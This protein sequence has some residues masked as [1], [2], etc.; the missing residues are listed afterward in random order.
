SAPAPLTNSVS[1]SASLAATPGSTEPF[2]PVRLK[3][4]VARAPPV[5]VASAGPAQPVAQISAPASASPA[6]PQAERTTSNRADREAPKTIA[7]VEPQPAPP[8]S[9]D[10]GTGKGVLGVLPARPN[11]TTAMAYADPSPRPHSVAVAQT[12]APVPAAEAAAA[13]PSTAATKPTLKAGT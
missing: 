13:P 5:K 3:A 11:A 9:S 7:R 6:S 10:Y 12:T 8:P 4:V 2:L 1:S